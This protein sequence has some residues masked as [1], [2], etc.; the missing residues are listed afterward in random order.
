VVGEFTMPSLGADMEAGKVIEWL[1]KP[2]DE[3][4]RGDIVAVVDTD[5]ADVD[6]EIFEDGI[7]EEILVGAGERVDVGTPLARI[8][9]GGPAPSPAREPPPSPPVAPPLEPPVGPVVEPVASE[10]AVHS[11]LVRRRAHELG[12]DLGAVTGSGPD[13]AVTRADVEHAA[14]R[15]APSATVA[16]AVPVPPAPVA[17]A[18][19]D[20]RASPRARRLAADL[21]VDLG[22]VAGSGP[23][24]TVTGDDV[25]SAHGEPTADTVAPG[26]RP[27]EPG[28]TGATGARSDRDASMRRAI[29]TRMAR[30]N[31]EIPHYYLEVRIDFS[32]ARAWLDA[33]NAE[34]AVA[35][36][37]IPA[38]LLLKATALAAREVSELNGFWVDD[39]PQ[40]APGVNVGLVISLRRGGLVAPAIHATDTLRLDEVMA[41]M[42]DLVARAR[43]GRLRSSEMSDPTITMTNIGEQ[44]V[45]KVF[46]VI[47]PPQLAIVG[48]GAISEQPWAADGM[49][50]ARPVVIATVAGDHRATDG[51]TGARFLRA[52]DR[53]LRDPEGL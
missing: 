16:P 42:R 35:E 34:R 17:P 3:V 37:V 2:G 32:R 36:R 10:A 25:T 13:G 18:R 38:A 24:G 49:V 53:L 48:F 23:S 46:G 8:R 28:V 52:V 39:G 40:A 22:G 14:A 29:A 1:V 12:V 41:A 7:V 26:L 43:A 33:F 19:T 45:D 4:H 21:G 51:A 5:K 50:G 30:A 15:A 9:S 44:G 47:F 31:R 6:V 27:E 20:R 11:P